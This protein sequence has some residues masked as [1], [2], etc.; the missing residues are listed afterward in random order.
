MLP[1]LTASG[2]LVAQQGGVGVRAAKVRPARSDRAC[3]AS[4]SAVDAILKKI[5]R[6]RATQRRGRT[7]VR[8]WRSA[9]YTNAGKSTLFNALTDAGTPTENRL[10]RTL[11]PSS[12]A[13]ARRRGEAVFA[14]TVGFIRK[15]PHHLVARPQHARGIGRATGAAVVAASH[16]RWQSRWRLRR[17]PD[18]ARRRSE[19]VLTVYN[20]SDCS[21]GAIATV[22]VLGLRVSPARACRRCAGIVRRLSM[23]RRANYVRRRAKKRVAVEQ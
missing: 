15:L 7:G 18:G 23:R 11:E 13:D 2:S 14:D 3:C 9:G 12:G 4:A 8:P 19:H 1:R 21:S 22:T 16:P 17:G 5:E 20:K 6:T 10:S